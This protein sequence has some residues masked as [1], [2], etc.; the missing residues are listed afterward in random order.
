MLSIWPYI[1]FH[2]QNN[3]SRSVIMFP[4]YRWRNWVSDTL[5]DLAMA[6]Q[7]PYGSQNAI[8]D[9]FTSKVCYLSMAPAAFSYLFLY[10]QSLEEHLCY[11]K[12]ST[13]VFGSIDSHLLHCVE[14]PPCYSLPSWG[15]TYYH[16]YLASTLYCACSFF[17]IPI[18]QM[19]AQHI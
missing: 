10:T 7:V 12:C 18:Q 11:R 3:P 1:T 6:M 4:F 19:F 9:L 8:L 2:S 5:T 15:S 13:D 14:C 17:W 16:S